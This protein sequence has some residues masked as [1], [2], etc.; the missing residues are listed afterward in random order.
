MDRV[1]GRVD[2]EVVRDAGRQTLRHAAENVARET[3]E[4]RH[5]RFKAMMAAAQRLLQQAQDRRG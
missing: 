1:V 3:V 5:A 4:Q 2:Q